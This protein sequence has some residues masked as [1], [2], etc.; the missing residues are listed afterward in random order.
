MKLNTEEYVKRAIEFH[1]NKYDYSK[2]NYT[3]FH[4]SIVII[5]PKH[6]E[7]SQRA[8]D[9]LRYGCKK[10]GIERS[11]N[12]TRSTKEKFVSKANVAHNNK[13]D[14]SKINYVNSK[15]KITIICPIHGEFEQT[16]TKHL[17]SG[18]RKCAGNVKYTTTEF[19]DAANKIHSNKY[20][21]GLVRYEN[22]TTKVLIKCDEHG[23]FKQTPHHHL[24]GK[25]CPTCNSSSVGERIIKEFLDE[26]GI[27][28]ER[29][30]TFK[31]CKYK[32][33]LRFD[34]YVPK[35][36][37]VVEYDGPQ[38][39]K[40]VSKF[41]SDNLIMTQRRDKIKNEYCLR[42]GINLE[43]IKYCSPL[44]LQKRLSDLLVKYNL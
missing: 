14:Y 42:E 39:F 35:I 11:K 22:I 33:L 3:G 25:G 20:D 1:G 21:Y 44:K 5:C 29:E 27:K 8:S 16:P 26:N 32:K 30:K 24:S 31:G 38:H 18:C 41:G 17:Y 43:R 40:S 23:V 37:L 9:H 28:Y 2:V 10:C 36:N 7:F 6:G 15:T 13:Y 12:G 34:F 4:D 19:V